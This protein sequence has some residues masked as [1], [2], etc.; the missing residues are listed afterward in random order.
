M[1]Y[2]EIVPLHAAN[3]GPMT[4]A[5]NWTYFLPGRH[6]LLIDAGVGQASHLDALAEARTSGPSHVVV[7]HAHGDHASGAATIAD[8]WTDTAFS[9]YPWPDRDG[10]Y[11][12]AWRGLADGEAVPAGDEEVI[13]VHTPGHAPD[14]IAL[15]HPSTR[16]LFSA[17]LVTVGTTVVILAT[18]G[19]RLADYLSSLRRV[20]ALAPKRL[21][22][23]HGEA[24]D[25]P[26]PLLEKYLAHRAQR[27]V[28]VLAGLRAGTRTIEG[29]VAD[30]YR[31]LSPA[32]VPMARESVLAHLLKLEEEGRARRVGD[33]WIE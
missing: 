31:G 1:A 14:H 29:L 19:G 16:T 21:L 10:R 11:P 15:W 33:E 9:K 5:G 8:R 23:A 20:I 17:D 24:I 22:P 25:D 32:L 30:I 3:P 4:G 26:R 12:V 13:V 7:T 18:H 6:P 28:Q 2:R 27:E